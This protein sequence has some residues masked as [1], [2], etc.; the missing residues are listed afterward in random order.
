VPFG[1]LVKTEQIIGRLR[2]GEKKQSI[3][4]DVTDYGFEE[5]VKQFKVRRRFYK[6]KAKKIVEI[7]RN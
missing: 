5:C 6:K 7:E 3:L 2:Y 4:V 1:S